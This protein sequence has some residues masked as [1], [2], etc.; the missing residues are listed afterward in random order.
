[1]A[2]NASNGVQMPIWQAE[3]RNQLPNTG[4]LATGIGSTAG[5]PRLSR[6]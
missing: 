3:K 1:M 6:G 4:Q 2:Y 5:N